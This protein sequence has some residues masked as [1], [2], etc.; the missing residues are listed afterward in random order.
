MM[1]MNGKGVNTM[2]TAEE[3]IAYLELELA[4]AY[5]QHD[6]S[7]GVDRQQTLVHLIR[8]TTITHLLEAIRDK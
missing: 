4:D 1:E 6:L 8:A 5:E 3:I 7:K 2:K